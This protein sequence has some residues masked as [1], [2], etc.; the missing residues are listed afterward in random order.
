MRDGGPALGS[1]HAASWMVPQP[2]APGKLA[3]GMP[4]PPAHHA[5]AFGCGVPPWP[6]ELATSLCGCTCT[7]CSSS[8][9]TFPHA[10]PDRAALACSMPPPSRPPSQRS[11][12]P[13]SLLL[14][15]HPTPPHSNLP[16]RQSQPCVQPAL[17]CLP[18]PPLPP[19][20]NFPVLQASNGLEGLQ[21]YMQHRTSVCLVF[22]DLMMPVL[23]GWATA[24]RMRSFEEEQACQVGGRPPARA[25]QPRTA[26]QPGCIGVASFSAVSPHHPLEGLSTP[27]QPAH[28]NPLTHPPT[29]PPAHPLC[30]RQPPSWPTPLRK[31]RLGRPCGPGALRAA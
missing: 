30:V 22:L 25:A 20:F 2:P 11:A 18:H 17:T 1:S 14:P 5:L 31:C 29:H 9:R 27:A 19:Q 12:P 24:L 3:C 28:A 13:H 16:L 23:D 6:P 15:P 7:S 10:Q 4:P 21:L 26:T 8:A